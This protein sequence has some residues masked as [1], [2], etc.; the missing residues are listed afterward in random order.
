MIFYRYV[1]LC[2]SETQRNQSLSKATK[3]HWQNITLKPYLPEV[4]QNNDQAI[5]AVQKFHIPGKKEALT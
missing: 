5:P 1:C 4:K 2:L 3:Q